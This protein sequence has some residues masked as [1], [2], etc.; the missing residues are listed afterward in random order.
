VWSHYPWHNVGS[1]AADSDVVIDELDE[2]PRTRRAAS[3]LV[4]AGQHVQMLFR[5]GRS[6]GP[7]PPTPRRDPA[8][9]S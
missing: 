3:A 7:L 2:N 5:L 6:P 9:V 8:G 1:F 4:P